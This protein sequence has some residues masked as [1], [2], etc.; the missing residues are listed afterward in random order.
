MRL[1]F[2][3]L[4]IRWKITLVIMLTT[5]LVLLVTSAAF[6]ARD[7]FEFRRTQ[8][9]ELA[10]LARI[11]GR[12]SAAAL[13]FGD[14]PAAEE[15]LS[16]LS[17]K[18]HM[19]SVT[20]RDRSGDVFAEFLREGAS[21]VDPPKLLTTGSY[22]HDGHLDLFRPVLLDNEQIGT[23]HV[24]QD[25]D[26]FY[27]RLQAYAGMTGSILAVVFVAALI[28]SWRLQRVVSGSIVNLAATAQQVSDH[29]DFSLR[30][31]RTA[32]DEIGILTTAFNK[33][34]DHIEERDE[35]LRQHR[36]NLEEQVAQRTAELEKANA[37]LRAEMEERARLEDQIQ[38]AQKLE[39]LGVLAGGIAHDFNNLLMG[40]LG[41]ADMAAL[42]TP[43][44]SP[45]HDSLDDVKRAAQRA[46]ELCQQMLA[47][48]GRGHFVKEEVSVND[49]VENMAHLL[50]ASISKRALLRFDLESNLPLIEADVPQ[51]RQIVMN[52]VTNASEAIGSQDGEIVISTGNR[53]C[54]AE[55]LNSTYLAEPVPEGDY[56]WL[57]VADTG[58]GMD[59]DVQEKIFDP[60]F[61]T[62]FTG[63]GLGLAAVL[64]IMRGHAGALTVES[65]PEQGSALTIFFPALEKA[66]K[67]FYSL[68]P[69]PESENEDAVLI[70]DDEEPVRRVAAR[71]VQRAGFNVLT[72]ADGEKA[73]EIFR[74]ESHR[75]AAVL[76][77][78]TM[79][80]MD[81]NET[82]HAMR[83]LRQDVRVI[84]SSGYN[85]EEATARLSQNGLAGFIQK[86]YEYNELVNKLHEALGA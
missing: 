58:C 48:S 45:V 41:N 5:G 44:D 6:V 31:P 18:P 10:T 33:M 68:P 30:A 19:L 81:G 55:F 80:H 75:I 67:T 13:V 65:S 63:R 54:N 16:A 14:V 20:I 79:P 25:M 64:G 32:R 26:A 28:L 3:N 4:S 11:V 53:Y 77:D 82:F 69:V 47:Y 22:Y 7:L 70:V 50:Q 86:P 29:D 76:L 2:R 43:P 27:A 34:L 38:Q 52:L 60:F 49:V 23:V 9:Q 40:I 61:S 73:L 66:T 84:L 35:R 59:Q 57:S 71:I 17:A 56:V 1:L 8:E 15:T 51:L 39:S 72:A 62:K 37:E 85:E 46:A 12:N 42:D 78:L 74:K 83:A 24:R 21:V 36:E